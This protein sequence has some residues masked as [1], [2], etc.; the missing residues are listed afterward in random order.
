MVE[1]KMKF[2]FVCGESKMKFCFIQC[3]AF[4]CELFTGTEYQ[5]SFYLFPSRIDLI[6]VPT[7]PCQVAPCGKKK[8]KRTQMHTYNT[9][10][11]RHKTQIH[12]A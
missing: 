2:C 3:V 5:S 10:L 7:E 11:N 1:S 4:Q 9:H 12:A 6:V 8:K